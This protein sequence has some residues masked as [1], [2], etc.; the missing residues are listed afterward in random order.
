MREDRSF[1]ER[2]K[3]LKSDEPKKRY[4]LVCEGEK[5]ENT[6]FNKVINS[7]R[8][9]KINPL[10]EI[11]PILRSFNEES[12]SNPKKIV[13]C[14]DKNLKEQESQKYSYET[15]LNII[16]DYLIEKEHISKTRLSQRAV[17]EILK[18]TLVKSGKNLDYKT[19]NFKE[20]CDIIAEELIEMKLTEV[21]DCLDKIVRNSKIGYKKGHDKICF[22]VDR[23]KDSFTKEQYDEVIRKCNKEGFLFFLSN[24][25]F[26]FWLLLHY[27]DID[28]LDED[29]LK[30]NSKVSESKNSKR[31]VEDQLCKRLKGYK[32]TNNKAG[33][34]VLK[35]DTAIKNVKNYCDSIS[36]LKDKVG[37]N[38]GDLFRELRE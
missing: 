11:I 24:P 30:E 34:L 37:S 38:L 17:Y 9:L 14:L 26:E 20:V 2:T 15:I 4:F 31:Y 6:Y 18:T 35:V 21:M 16:M 8:P 32:K 12:W 3:V 29:K 5:T 19:D 23:D 28:D 7:H 27:E 25:C 10:I 36:D 13:D 33:E 22:I 1:G